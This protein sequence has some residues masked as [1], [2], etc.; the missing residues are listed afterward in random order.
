[1]ALSASNMPSSMLISITCAPFSTCWRA[2]VR[3]SSYCSLIIKRAKA[4]EPVT[5]VRSP[6]LTNNESSST[7]KGSKPE[8]LRVRGKVGTTLGGISLI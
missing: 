6:T 5:L 7:T 2:T 3:A 4:L 1:M 8:S